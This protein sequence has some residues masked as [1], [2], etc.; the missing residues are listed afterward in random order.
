M[1]ATVAPIS[2]DRLSAPMRQYLSERAA[3]YDF[4][5]AR[6]LW[7]DIPS[8]LHH[9]EDAMM[10]FLRGNESHEYQKPRR[11]F[12]VLRGWALM[13]ISSHALLREHSGVPAKPDQSRRY[14]KVV[15]SR[16]WSIPAMLGSTIGR[17]KCLAWGMT[18]ATQR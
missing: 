12:G 16:W 10:S 13:F 2:F 3:N 7:S 11:W 5:S 8:D 15:R 1:T 17:A 18:S 9:S 4:Y 14:E 6:D